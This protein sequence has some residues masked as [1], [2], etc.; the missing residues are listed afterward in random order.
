MKATSDCLDQGPTPDNHIYTWLTQKKDLANI[1]TV[2]K[3]SM[4]DQWS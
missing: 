1:F 2:Y 3:L 4:Y